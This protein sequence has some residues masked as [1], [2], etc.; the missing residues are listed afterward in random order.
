[1]WEVPIEKI[2]N[3]TQREKFAWAMD[4]ADENFRFADDTNQWRPSTSQDWY[5]VLYLL[6]YRNSFRTSETHLLRL[7]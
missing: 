4:V 1:M 2:Y 6:G 3:K 7:N 5:D